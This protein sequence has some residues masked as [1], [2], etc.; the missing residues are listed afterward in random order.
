MS[1]RPVVDDPSVV[2]GP[3]GECN[4]RKADAHHVRAPRGPHSKDTSGQQLPLTVTRSPL[5]WQRS[6]P[7]GCLPKLTVRVRFPSSAPDNYP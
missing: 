2:D 4:Q 7:L 3:R 6:D 5:S 1:E